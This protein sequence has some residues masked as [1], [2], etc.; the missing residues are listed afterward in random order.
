MTEIIAALDVDTLKQEEDLLEKLR[1][2]VSFYK[3]GMR[4]FTAHGKRAIDLI[5]KEDAKVFLDLKLHDI[6]ETVL[7]TVR[8]AQRLGV[9]AVSF[10][11]SGGADMLKAAAEV[12]PRPK[13]WGVTVLTSFA[14]EDLELVWPGAQIEPTILRL[15]RLGKA[16]GADGIICSAADVPVLQKSLG[17]DVDFITPGI[18]PASSSKDDQSRVATPAEAARRGIK[19][20]VVG[21]PITK[22]PDPLKAAQDIAREI[23]LAHAGA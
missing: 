23:K 20:I 4:L 15:A 19:Y 8:Q 12:N 5:L 10:H 2:T 1:G 22:A 14:Q 7:Q 16:H 17:T 13:L 9:H 21:R 6:P 18:R 11:L 3:I